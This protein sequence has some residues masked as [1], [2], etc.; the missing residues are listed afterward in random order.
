[1]RR[2]NLGRLPQ[3]DVLQCPIANW[4][5]QKSRQTHRLTRTPNRLIGSVGVTVPGAAWLISKHPKKSAAHHG[6]DEHHAVPVPD[7]EK[8]P[9]V[10]S[11]AGSRADSDSDSDSG[12][13]SS[14]A[15]STPESSDAE[16]DAAKSSS[17]D[18][19]SKKGSAD[20]EEGEKKKGGPKDP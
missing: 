16:S 15:Q 6:G 10:E 9:A 5:V 8:A 18:V 1:M 4:E 19:P 3:S 20:A 14:S 13:D 2:W 11:G 7:E 17:S 12:D